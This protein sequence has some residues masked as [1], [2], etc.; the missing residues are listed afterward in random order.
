VVLD[1]EEIE[2]DDDARSDIVMMLNERYSECRR[3]A[4]LGAATFASRGCVVTPGPVR[5]AALRGAGRIVRPARFRRWTSGRW[6]DRGRLVL[7]GA[8]AMG[9]V[10]AWSRGLVKIRARAACEPDR[11]VGDRR[12]L[13][14]LG[15]APP[16]GA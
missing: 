13:L 12:R 3:I 2:A 15:A 10:V 1:R 7:F 4:S 8:G 6:N 16:R 9:G 5:A 11:A 14:D